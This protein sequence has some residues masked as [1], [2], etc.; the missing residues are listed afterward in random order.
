M[1]AAQRAV[2]RQDRGAPREA[3]RGFPDLYGCVDIGAGKLSDFDRFHSLM[4]ELNVQRI[5]GLM[6][7]S[8]AG[9]FPR[10]AKAARAGALRRRPA[11]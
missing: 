7:D 2:A 10:A 1:L 9:D 11:G 3:C 8:E 6:S 4:N 5:A